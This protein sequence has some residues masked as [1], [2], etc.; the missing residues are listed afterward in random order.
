VLESLKKQNECPEWVNE[1]AYATL[2]NGYLLP[3]ETPKAAYRRLAKTAADILKKPEFENKFFNY[4]WNNWLCPSSPVLSNFGTNRGLAVSC[5]GGVAED[6]LDDIFKNY[7]EMAMLTKNGGGIG[8]YYGK[9]RARGTSIKGNGIT[10]GVI[11]F[12]KVAEQTIQA[13]SQ[14]S[15]RRGAIAA[16][17]DITHGDAEEFIN[18]KRP[19][20]DP[21]RRCLSNNFHNAVC[22]SDEFMND[23]KLNKFNTRHLWKEL[24]R[25]RVETGEPYLMF[26]DTANRNKPSTI[27]ER[28]YSSQLCSE[29]F[30][31]SNEEMT[32]TCVLSS[33]NLARYDEWKDTDLIEISIEF[34]DAVAQDFIDRGSIIPGLEKSVNF[35]R[36]YRALGLGVLGWHTLLQKKMIPFESFEAMQLNS[37]IFKKLQEKS[38]INTSNATKLAIAPT[39]SNSILSGGISQGIEPIIA[40]CYIQ[41]TAK[42]VF[43]KKNQ[44]L[45]KLL[46]LK[47]KNEEKI[48]L[49][50][51]ANKGS[52][53]SLD[54]L[55]EEEKKVFLTAREI[56]QFAIVR[57]AGQRQKFIDQGQSLNLFFAMPNDITD[58][59][60][61]DDLAKYIHQVHTEAFDLGVKSLYYLKTESI[62]KGESVIKN[63]SDCASCE[64]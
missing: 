47:N 52:V 16:Y 17:L 10:E 13:V 63:A 43:I 44:E 36:K 26:S 29:I 21:S 46:E 8:W 6:T 37:E 51:N 28:I 5:F 24:L 55:S 25:A 9:L 14:G 32:Y 15:T 30:L 18:I 22:I 34:L 40:N 31:P 39:F 42:G 45:E 27:K 1:Q 7:H 23:V 3:N 57:Q 61:K 48:W 60:T 53:R 35:T 58:N 59:Q 19:T 20:G 41:K 33:L 50:I 62:L 49:E 11:P 12:L 4:I 38:N 56:N 64:G 54:F 2:S